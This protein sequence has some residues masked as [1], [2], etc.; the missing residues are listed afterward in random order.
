MNCDD[1]QSQIC[2]LLD[3]GQNTHPDAVLEL[4]LA[5][6]PSCREFHAAWTGLD[7]QLSHL[8]TKA[9]LPADFKTTLMSRLP[10]PR[11]RLLPAEVAALRAQ[12]EREYRAAMDLTLGRYLFCHPAKL[13]RLVAL[14]GGIV[15]AGLL[16]PGVLRE[17]LAVAR[18]AL[19]EDATMFLLCLSVS[20]AALLYAALHAWRPFRYQLPRW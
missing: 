8:V 12:Y 14:A 13:L 6:C 17:L 2:D 11:P 15:S 5:G 9:A 1:C 10:E 19:R 3:V 16:L 7:A 4:H 20:L 18:A